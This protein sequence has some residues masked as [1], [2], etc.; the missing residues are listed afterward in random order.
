MC[1][2]S[3]QSDTC[4]SVK[5]TTPNFFV[6]SATGDNAKG[7]LGVPGTAAILHPQPIQVGAMLQQ[8][9][10]AAAVAVPPA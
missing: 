3:V 4:S 7:Q 10:A 2:S 1:I 5:T 8:A 9:C 6:D